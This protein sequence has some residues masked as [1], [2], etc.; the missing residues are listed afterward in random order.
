MKHILQDKLAIGIDLGGTKVRMALIADEGK[1]LSVNE[2][3]THSERGSEGVLID[4]L[5]DIDKY[6]KTSKKDVHVL[7]VGVAGQ[8][9]FEGVVQSAP[10]L[11]WNNFPLK[12][13][14]E[15]ELGL[16]TIVVNDVR[17]ATFGEW[18]YGS[19]KKIADLVVVF[20]G[21]GI[22]GGVIT[23]GKMLVGCNNSAGELG[24]LTVVTNG[25][26]CHCR[27]HGCLEAY[28]GGWAIAERA[29]EKIKLNP[30]KG[31]RLFFGV[32]SIEKITAKTVSQAANEGDLLAE[33]LIRETA[34]YLASG[35]VGIVNAFN[36]CLLVLGG[37]VIEGMPQLIPLVTD[38]I[39]THALKVAV[40]NLSIKKAKLN[41]D[42]GVVGAAALAQQYL[43]EL[44]Y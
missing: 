37:G 32:D 36:P 1:V 11:G 3:S 12:Q 30:E 44:K 28:V 8:V 5:T 33:S 35:L 13:R 15:K 40:R 26:P 9:N 14:L 43:G 22:G 19:G 17:A 7:G 18:R 34:Q 27:N 31:Q 23:G 24:H 42:A 29:Q 41:G 39:N 25:R 38:F 4:L 6:L 21:T 20:I 10:N 16:P 2:R